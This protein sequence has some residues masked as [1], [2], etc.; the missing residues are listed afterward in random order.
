VFGLQHW[1]AFALGTD[2]YRETYRV[3]PP[4]ESSSLLSEL[5]KPNISH[6]GLETIR[7]AIR[8]GAL[9]AAVFTA[10]PSRPQS[11]PGV[12]PDNSPE[13]EI[14]LRA[15]NLLLPLAGYGQMRWLADRHNQRTDAYL[16]P[17][18]VHAIA[19][20]ALAGG[21]PELDSLEAARALVEEG[22]VQPALEPLRTGDLRI[23][24]F[25]DTPTG[26]RSLQQ[27]ARILEKS[28]IHNDVTM[29]GIS[30]S[31]EKIKALEGLGARIFA[32]LDE[33][34]E[35]ARRQLTGE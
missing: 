20:M 19:A 10:R 16:K 1:E 29:F 5:D 26:I 25:E 9:G 2:S 14:P 17:S 7:S 30:G 3:E 35:F 13:A 22:V 6:R 32:T 33:G 4:L 8:A 23:H 34:V 11:L 27:A 18:P 28:G 24:L 15:M 12:M 31:N 21:A